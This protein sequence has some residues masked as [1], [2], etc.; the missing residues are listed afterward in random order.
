MMK[1]MKKYK[2]DKREFVVKMWYRYRGKPIVYL[3]KDLCH[4]LR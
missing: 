1:I 2:G 4:S 3:L